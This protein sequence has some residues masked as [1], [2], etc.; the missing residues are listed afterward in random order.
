[1]NNNLQC[2][3]DFVTI[4]E[5]KARVIAFLVMLLI[6]GFLV[7]SLVPIIAFLVI[8]FFMRAVNLGKYSALGVLSDGVIS[9]LKIGSKPVDRA[10]KRFAA[11]IGFVFCTTML[12]LSLFS[13]AAGTRI[14]GGVMILFAALEAFAGFCAGCYVYTA[15]MLLFKKRGK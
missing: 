15:G 10:P 2:P 8:D 1:M 6:I 3:V 11:L 14:A 5:H 7:T 12:T 13:L 9:L 4:N